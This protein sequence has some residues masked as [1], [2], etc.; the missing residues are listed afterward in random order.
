[1]SA[2]AESR[3]HKRVEIL[4]GRTADV[5][6]A[7]ENLDKARASRTKA[8]DALKAARASLATI[9]KKKAA[10]KPPTAKRITE[11]PKKGSAASRPLVCTVCRKPAVEVP[12]EMLACGCPFHLRCIKRWVKADK[13]GCPTCLA[14]DLFMKFRG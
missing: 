9:K 14:P 6:R 11:Q 3:V 2:A 5:A 1:M 7:K 4:D 12:I 8:A 13:Q 10:A